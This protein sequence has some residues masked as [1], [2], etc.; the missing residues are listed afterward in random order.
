MGIRDPIAPAEEYCQATTG[1]DRPADDHGRRRADAYLDG[2]GLGIAEAAGA[3]LISADRTWN[4]VEGIQ[5][6]SPV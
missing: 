4:S 3:R 5:N 2:R 6:H 1:F